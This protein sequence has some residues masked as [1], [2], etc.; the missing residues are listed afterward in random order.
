MVQVRKAE[1]K[2]ISSILSLLDEVNEIHEKARP[3]IF[4]RGQK[5]HEKEVEALLEDK[6]VHILVAEEETVLG[7][8][9][10]FEEEQKEDELMKERRFLYLD[11]LCVDKKARGK[12]VGS[13]LLR[14][15]EKLARSLSYST[16]TLRVWSFNE[17]A[18]AFYQKE[19]YLPLYEEREKKL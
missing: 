6:K 2:D 14:E 17:K 18:I 13:L 5:Y 7:Y 1:K 16:I 3:D 11:D 15:A 19:G 8:A 4:K 10:L 9:I 12:G